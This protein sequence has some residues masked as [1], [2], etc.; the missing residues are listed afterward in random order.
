MI[1]LRGT[2]PIG[3]SALASERVLATKRLLVLLSDYD[4]LER[5]GSD[6]LDELRAGISSALARISEIDAA[7]ADHDTLSPLEELSQAQRRQPSSMS[8]SQR[9]A[10]SRARLLAALITLHEMPASCAAATRLLRKQ[11]RNEL[12]TIEASRRLEFPP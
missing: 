9:H 6:E 3:R 2:R 4:G 1:A 5:A 10:A 8:P 7:L 11:I 12:R